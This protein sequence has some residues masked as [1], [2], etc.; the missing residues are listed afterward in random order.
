MVDVERSGVGGWAALWSD[1]SVVAGAGD[2][3]FL[4]EFFFF[5]L[6]MLYSTGRIARQGRARQTRPRS[7]VCL[8][9]S[10]NR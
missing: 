8:L 9:G 10:R 1:G 7:W 4:S 2:A 3:P 6:H 5:P